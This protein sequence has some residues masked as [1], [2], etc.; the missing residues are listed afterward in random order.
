MKKIEELT[1]EQ[2]EQL[3]VYK[4]KWLEIGLSTVPCDR[5][6][7]EDAARAAYKIAGLEEPKVFIWLNSPIEGAY[8]A[9][10]FKVLKGK[11]SQ[12]R[13]QVGDQVWDQVY[14]CG[15]GLHDASWLGFYSYFLDVL[16]LEC[17]AKLTP[18]MNICKNSGWWWPFNGLVI[19]TEKPVE[20]NMTNGRLHK[21]GGPALRYKDGFSLFRL[22]GINV[23]KEIVETPKEKFTKEM[24]VNE[25][26]ADIR[27]EIIRKL[28]M[29][30]VSKLLDYK[31]IDEKHGYQLI[32]FDIGDGRIRP[33][34]KMNNPSMNLV[35]I[36]G[37]MPEIK[38][39]EGAICYR[40]SLT[41]FEM[42][43]ALS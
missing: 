35:H 37:V 2:K 27:R 8:A 15:Y 14:N 6:K 29:E 21:D 19:F 31:I 17:C 24:I 5:K 13:A 40:N 30:I 9:A 16:N 41:K 28:G 39:V 11:D 4:D 42:P 43:R 25:K 32:T 33:Y 3:S 26:N 23:S 18:F 36:E 1:K 10:Y 20:I 7:A 22:N 12:V 38:T 34:L